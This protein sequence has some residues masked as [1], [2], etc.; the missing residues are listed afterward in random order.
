MKLM[1]ERVEK[2][3]DYTIGSLSVDDDWQ[4]WTCEDEVRDGPKVPGQTA[5]PAGTYQV[6]VTMSNRFQRPLPLLVNVPDFD[7]IRIHP[8]NT[9]ADTDGCILPGCDRYANSVGRSRVAFE[10]LFTKIKD[11]IAKGEKVTIEIA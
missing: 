11:A 5:I 10:A 3:A 4:C 2:A 7:G 9:A 6:I 8:G 1:L